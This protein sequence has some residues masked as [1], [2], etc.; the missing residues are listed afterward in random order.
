MKIKHAFRPGRASSDCR[1][2]LAAGILAAAGILLYDAMTPS[3]FWLQEPQQIYT[4]ESGILQRNGLF[5]S[6]E[7]CRLTYDFTHPDYAVLIQTYGIDKIAGTGTEFQRALR[8]MDE[9]APR[10]THKSDY[11]NHVRFAALSLLAYSLD[12]PRQGINCLN[13]A[14]I[15]NEM[16]LALGI[17]SR[18]VTLLPASVYDTEC[19]VVNEIWDSTLNKWIM[20]DITDNSYWIDENGTPLSVL[21]IRYKCSMQEFCTS[22]HPGDDLSHPELLREKHMDNILYIMKNLAYMMYNDYNGVGA[23]RIR[24]ALVPENMDVDHKFLIDE[25]ACRRSPL[26][27]DVR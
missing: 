4:M 26:E 24:Y 22:V 5:A 21:E 9:Y 7:D 25:A 15:L 10:L 17:Y 12:N 8:L 14:Q 18:A 2:L 20:L 3:I 23:G 1:I 13:K 27:A 19:H 11:T 6:G 16:C